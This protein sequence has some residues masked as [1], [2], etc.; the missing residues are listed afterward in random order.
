MPNMS[1]PRASVTQLTSL[2]TERQPDSVRR[3]A[4]LASVGTRVLATSALPVS[5]CSTELTDTHTVA[6]ANHSLGG[7]TMGCHCQSHLHPC[8]PEP[9]LSCKVL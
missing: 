5:R 9:V 1:L 3:A 4:S 6:V 2:R 7:G 8:H